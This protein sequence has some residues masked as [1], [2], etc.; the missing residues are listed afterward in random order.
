MITPYSPVHYSQSAA[1]S[2]QRPVNQT[3]TDSPIAPQTLQDD[4]VSISPQAQQQAQATTEPAD[5]SANGYR[6]AAGLVTE[7]QLDQQQK[8]AEQAAKE[9]STPSPTFSELNQQVV[10]RMSRVDK[11]KLEEIQK[12]IDELMAKGDLTESEVQTL[13]QLNKELA[14]EYEKAGE[15]IV[16]ENGG[17]PL[18]NVSENVEGMGSVMDMG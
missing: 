9:D 2:P 11:E 7:Q 5:Q 15:R 1:I 4:K 13:E 17:Q 8:A 18:K 10:D 6:L 12:K 3:D 14:A 16:L